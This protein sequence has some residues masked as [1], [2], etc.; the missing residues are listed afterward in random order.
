VLLA[1]N[2]GALSEATSRNDAALYGP[3]FVEVDVPFVAGM[4]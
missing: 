1:Y 4:R 2:V 3:R